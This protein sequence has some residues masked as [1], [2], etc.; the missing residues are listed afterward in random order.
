MDMISSIIVEDSDL[1]K[2][3]EAKKKSIKVINSFIE[4]NKRILF[5][6]PLF[7]FELMLLNSGYE[8]YHF[9]SLYDLGETRIYHKSSYSEY[10]KFRNEIKIRIDLM[11]GCMGY[12]DVYSREIGHIHSLNDDMCFLKQNFENIM[13]G[14]YTAIKIKPSKPVDQAWSEPILR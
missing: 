13:D 14:F 8:I 7:N 3:R 12:I 11:K 5:I 4:N 1:W 6:R 10:E 2:N 9:S